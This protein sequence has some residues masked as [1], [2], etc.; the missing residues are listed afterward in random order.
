MPT[1]LKTCEY[2]SRALKQKFKNLI[3]GVFFSLDSGVC[4]RVER[5]KLVHE[6]FEMLWR[7]GAERGKFQNL[8]KNWEKKG[9]AYFY[10][11]LIYGVKKENKG[12]F[13][14][15]WSGSVWED[16]RL[17]KKGVVS[18]KFRDSLLVLFKKTTG[19]KKS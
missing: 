18:D 6:L 9:N 10:L 13:L 3:C 4:K 1:Y 14:N 16:L 15:C 11:C 7:E 12:G 17:W 2:N 19:N 5:Q 8:R